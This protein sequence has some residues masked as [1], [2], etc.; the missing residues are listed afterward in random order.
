MPNWRIAA[1]VVMALAM[2][3][4][5]TAPSVAQSSSGAQE[6]RSDILVISLEE[7]FARSEFGIK[8]ADDYALAAN[9]LATENRQIEAE[10]ISEE[11]ALADERPTIPQA[12]F[13]AM[14]DAFDDKV[15]QIRTT[16][17]AKVRAL[18]QESEV[19][20]ARFFE[21]AQPVIEE[22]M[23]QR[24]AVVIIDRDSTVLSIRAIDITADAIARI[25]LASQAGEEAGIEE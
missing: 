12:E 13:R 18:G 8:V 14:A 22:I 6:T 15:Q 23:R 21:F 9:S 1:G 19:A 4:G 5:G 11:K 10:L 17:D 20:K 3:F 2:L 24:G 25:N 7:F 16:Q